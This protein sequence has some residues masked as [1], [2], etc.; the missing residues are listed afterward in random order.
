MP[1][2]GRIVPE[3]SRDDF[4]ELLYGNYRVI[5]KVGEGQVSVLTVRHGR[6]IL[7]VDE[8]MPNIDKP[9]LSDAH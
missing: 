8:I 4:S 2:G 9:I 7:Q 6:Q 5:Y 1:K 3:I